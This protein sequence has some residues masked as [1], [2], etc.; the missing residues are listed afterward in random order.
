MKKANDKWWMCVDFRAVNKA[1]P[2][3]NY[4]FLYIDKLVDATSGYQ[5]LSFMDAYFCYIH[6][7]RTEKDAPHM[8]F[9]A[10]SGIYHY[11]VMP[12]GL[13][14][15]GSIYQRMVNNYFL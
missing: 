3:N 7:E 8:T 13:I 12:L 10:A 14:N 6:I 5:L 11:T 4:P 9:Y 2:E 15:A 1:C